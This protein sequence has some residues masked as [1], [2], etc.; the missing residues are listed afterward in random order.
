MGIEILR[1]FARYCLNIRLE[2]FYSNANNLLKS[3][4]EL[5]NTINEYSKQRKLHSACCSFPL[6][7]ANWNF[8]I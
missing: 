2:I 5:S 1:H 7:L 4:L 8:V 6:S 3:E